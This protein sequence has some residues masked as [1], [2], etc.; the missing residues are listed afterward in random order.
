MS[1]KQILPVINDINAMIGLI[2]QK[3][4]ICTERNICGVFLEA[5]VLGGCKYF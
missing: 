2:S 4:N 3:I 5:K 1:F